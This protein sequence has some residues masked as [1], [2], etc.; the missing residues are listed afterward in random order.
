[1]SDPKRTKVRG[2]L[3]IIARVAAIIAK[4]ARALSGKPTKG[5]IKPRN[6]P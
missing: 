1:M 4:V 2:I 3:R 5:K 6:K